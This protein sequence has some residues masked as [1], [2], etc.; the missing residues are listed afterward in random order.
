MNV[1]G[2][3]RWRAIAPWDRRHTVAQVAAHVRDA[4]RPDSG[5]TV[6]PQV[7]EARLGFRKFGLWAIPP[8]ERTVLQLEA[9]DGASLRLEDEIA[10]IGEH[11]HDVPR[12]NIRSEAPQPFAIRGV[13]ANDIGIP[14]GLNGTGSV[15]DPSN[16][17][18]VLALDVGRVASH[19]CRDL[20]LPDLFAGLDVDCVH[21]ARCVGAVDHASH[22]A[23][24]VADVTAR[25]VRPQLFALAA[26]FADLKNGGDVEIPLVIHD[27]RPHEDSVVLAGGVV[28]PE[29]QALFHLAPRRPWVGRGAVHALVAMVVRPVVRIRRCGL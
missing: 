10:L 17:D 3:V 13:H 6:S 14:S 21:H 20:R 12:R 4:I 19:G 25:H 29:R 5:P 11:R 28:P 1:A 24:G 2:N 8:D 16:N 26:D 22:Q 15:L 18:A 27:G 23:G 7:M 9:I